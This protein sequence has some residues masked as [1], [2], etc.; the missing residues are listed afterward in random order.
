MDN[1]LSIN[2]TYRFLDC[3]DNLAKKHESIVILDTVPPTTMNDE[4]R[5]MNDSP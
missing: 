2:F 4:P 3:G 1:L 5:T